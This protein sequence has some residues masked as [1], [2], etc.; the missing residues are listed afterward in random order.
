MFGDV[1][2]WAGTYRQR[3]SNIG[4]VEPHR[5]PIEVRTL[6]D[7]AHSWLKYQ[8][9]KRDELAIRLHHRLV[10]IHPFLNGNGRHTRLMADLLVEKPGGERFNRREGDLGVAGPLRSDTWRP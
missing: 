4:N 8:S 5:I 10:A 1:W 6:F 3:E 9:Y 2:S 7:D